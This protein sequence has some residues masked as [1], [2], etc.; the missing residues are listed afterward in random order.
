MMTRVAS[1]VQRASSPHHV[2]VHVHVH[3]DDD[4]DDDVGVTVPANAS[5]FASVASRGGVDS[6]RF[7]VFTIVCTNSVV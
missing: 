3:D 6:Y 7:G 2:H 4:D 1:C 5:S